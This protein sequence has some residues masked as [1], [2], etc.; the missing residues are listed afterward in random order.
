MNQ[1]PCR[2]T[3][4][5]E[6]FH[7]KVSSFCTK[8]TSNRGLVESKT[9]MKR[10]FDHL[11]INGF[12]QRMAI[13]YD[14]LD[15]YHQSIKKWKVN[16]SMSEKP[17]SMRGGAI[18]S[19]SLAMI[20][21]LSWEIGSRLTGHLEYSVLSHL[22]SIPFWMTI[23]PFTSIALK[24]SPMVTVLEMIRNKS[25]M[26]LPMLPYTSMANLTFVLVAYGK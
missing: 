21:F 16:T 25:V 13:P 17:L 12:E 20:I 4:R 8:T 5:D 23:A 11:Y 18:T 1:R 19:S 24:M 15:P 3:L 10:A 6:I 14:Y 7:G 2:I 26:G 22:F 9:K